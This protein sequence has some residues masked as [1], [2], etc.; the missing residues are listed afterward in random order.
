MVR[1]GATWR[2]RALQVVDQLQTLFWDDDTGRVLHHRAHAE[3]LVVR[4][5]E[6][7]DG[8]VPSANSVAVSALS[9]PMPSSTTT[10]SA[11]RWNAPSP[12]LLRSSS[13]TR[14]LWPIWWSCRLWTDRV[15]VVV[16]GERPDL[17]AEVRRRW[18]PNAVVTWGDPDGGPLFAGRVDGEARDYICRSR[19]CDLPA[20]DV[21]TFSRQLDSVRS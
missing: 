8:A 18:L 14:P 1:D 5:Q 12:W 2:T 17:L 15:E 4:P 7:T 20:D 6:F 21:A 3:T 19:I 10:A 11:T 9:P 13:A 16:T